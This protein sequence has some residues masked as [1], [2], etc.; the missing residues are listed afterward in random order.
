[1]SAP[2]RFQCNLVVRGHAALLASE[3]TLDEYLEKNEPSILVSCDALLPPRASASSLHEA[4][5]W[6]HH[7]EPSQ[8]SGPS[9]GRSLLFE[10]SL[11]VEARGSEALFELP[12]EEF[13]E[14]RRE[15][16]LRGNVGAVCF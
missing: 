1:M 12:L 14:V 6:P 16:S 10:P 2:V 8:R 4:S 5:S 13:E 7:V 3:M 11:P 9:P 15:L